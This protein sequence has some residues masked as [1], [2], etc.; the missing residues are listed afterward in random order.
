QESG[1][2]LYIVFELQALTPDSRLPTFYGGLVPGLSSANRGITVLALLLLIITLMV[3]GFF[4]V[5]Y[6]RLTS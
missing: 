4:L 2:W 3:C 5:R 1:I 6:L